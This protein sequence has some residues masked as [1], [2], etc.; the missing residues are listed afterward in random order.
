[1]LNF[2]IMSVCKSNKCPMSIDSPK[3]SMLLDCGVGTLGQLFRLYGNRTKDV[4]KNLN[5]IF[6]SHMHQD[7]FMGELFWIH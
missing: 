7:H 3:E 5:A 4:L 2:D 1:M 6:I